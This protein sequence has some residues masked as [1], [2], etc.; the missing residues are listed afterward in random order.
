MFSFGALLALAI[1]SLEWA[2]RPRRWN[3]RRLSEGNPYCLPDFSS[4]HPDHSSPG[5]GNRPHRTRAVR[6]IS[7]LP[8]WHT[9]V[10]REPQPPHVEVQKV[11]Q[12]API[13]ILSVGRAETLRLLAEALKDVPGFRIAT[14]GNYRELWTVSP[15]RAADIV[16]L[17]PSLGEFELEESCRLV[18]QRW[19]HARILVVRHEA[20]FLADGLY[21]ERVHPNCG[22]VTLRTCIVRL[23]SRLDYWRFADGDR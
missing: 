11:G 6:G 10:P 3:A 2:T 22:F 5:G 7:W 21:D 23:T 15:D 12:L 17:H 16:V 8:L 1:A 14:A 18:R 20:E 9:Q 13:R 19:P 4:F